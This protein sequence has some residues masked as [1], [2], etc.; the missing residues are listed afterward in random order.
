[1]TLIGKLTSLNQR[2]SGLP[3]RFGDPRY[4]TV[5]LSYNGVRMVIEPDLKVLQA[6][7][8][9]GSKAMGNLKPEDWLSENVQLNGEEII[10][11]GIP[12]T[13]PEELVKRSRYEIGTN[14]YDCEY[15]NMSG[16]LTY[17]ALLRPYRG[18]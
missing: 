4:E 15:V 5:I 1:M 17:N 16:L 12:R 13:Y 6:N 3:S 10:V 9:E 14:T 11:F 7:S 2:L 18:R 8:P